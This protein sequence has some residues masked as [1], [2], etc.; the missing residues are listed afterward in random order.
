MA[1][2]GRI[3]SGQQRL[4]AY[5]LL[6]LLLTTKG[7]ISTQHPSPKVPKAGGLGCQDEGGRNSDSCSINGN[8]R[9][10][11]EALWGHSVLGQKSLKSL[12]SA[13]LSAGQAR[14]SRGQVSVTCSVIFP[15]TSLALCS[16]IPKVRE[17]ENGVIFRNWTTLDSKNEP[18]ERKHCWI[19]A[20]DLEDPKSPKAS[21]QALCFCTI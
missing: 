6:T 4:V 7:R 13:H 21:T 2:R 19:W 16:G 10:E 11:A 18:R 3:V 15:L 20:S 17:Y 9:F 12:P 8:I 1:A 5:Y 14:G